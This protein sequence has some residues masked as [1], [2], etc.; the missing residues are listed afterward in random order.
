LKKF[1]KKNLEKG[2]HTVALFEASKGIIILI[3]GFA[4]LQLVHGDLQMI[5]DSIVRH[6]HMNPARHNPHIFL[7][8]I[9]GISDSKIKYLAV[10]AFIYSIVRFVEAYG[11]WHYRPWAEWFAIL[12]GGIYIPVELIGLFRHATIIKGSIFIVNLFIVLFLIYIQIVNRKPTD[13]LK[14][15]QSEN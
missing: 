11:L 9:A 6:L 7:D 8:A 2:I 12:S 4:I 10:F 14:I 5:A 15:I 13:K 1:N 3:A